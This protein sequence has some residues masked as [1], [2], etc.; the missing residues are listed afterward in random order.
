M[1]PGFW[2]IPYSVV[3]CLL[4]SSSHGFRWSWTSDYVNFMFEILITCRQLK[5]VSH[6]QIEF[7]TFHRTHIFSHSLLPSCFSG[8][9]TEFFQFS[10]QV[11]E[12]FLRVPVLSRG[13]SSNPN[14]LQAEFTVGPVSRPDSFLVPHMSA[15]AYFSGFEFPFCF[16]HLGTVL[17]FF[18]TMYFKV[19][20][21]LS[22]IYTCLQQNRVFVKSGC[23]TV[24]PESL[25]Y[26]YF[27]HKFL[28]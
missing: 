19:L 12:G 7:G 27:C 22:S 6:T 18:Q 26:S 1:Y 2:I 11:L 20:K 23:H 13:L 9:Q 24:S 14:S 21:Y 10:F 5:F 3:L 4:L 15:G 8:W 17:A 28:T 16:W 25:W